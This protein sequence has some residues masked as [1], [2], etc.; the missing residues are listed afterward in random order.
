MELLRFATCS[1][2]SADNL[3]AS[4]ILIKPKPVSSAPAPTL[5]SL[6]IYPLLVIQ[7]PP[8]YQQLTVIGTYNDSSTADITTQCTFTSSNIA[9]LAFDST[10][11]NAHMLSFLSA[12]A[13]ASLGAVS[14]TRVF[15]PGE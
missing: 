1:K 11:G 10:V 13:T 9:R 4:L 15:A 14:N 2:T 7:A 8:D 5:L 6:T 12:T 3:F